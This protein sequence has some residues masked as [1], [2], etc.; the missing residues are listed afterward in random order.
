MSDPAEES[1][2]QGPEEP[3]GWLQEYLNEMGGN[4]M[5]LA[6]VLLPVVVLCLPAVL[7]WIFG[8]VWWMLLYIPI[9]AGVFLRLNAVKFYGPD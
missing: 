4:V 5:F 1:F 8:S 9:I 6:W 2:S 7:V 3:Q